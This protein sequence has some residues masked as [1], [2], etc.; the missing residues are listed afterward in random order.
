MSEEKY[1]L[2][3]IV[4]SL[5]TPFDEKGRVDFAS[6]ERLVETHL[7]EGAVG[8]LTTA[9]AAE[10]HELT[11][12]E[13]VEIVRLVKAVAGGRAEV[14]AG[15]TARKL[16][17]SLKLSEI[18]TRAGCE[19]VLIE[20]PATHKGDHG[21]TAEFVESFASVGMPMLMLQDLD[22]NGKGLAVDL[23]SDMFQRIEPFKCLKVEVT[24]C[25]PKYTTVIEATGGRLHVSGG[26]ASL[27]MIEALDRGVD[28]FLP[29]AMTK[30]FVAVM[31]Q[32]GAG[33]RETAK[34]VFHVMLPILAFT[35]Q[36][37]DVSIHFH[38]RLYHSRGVFTT[39]TVRIR[40]HGFDAHHQ[41]HA[42]ELIRYLD[43]VEDSS[44]I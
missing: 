31:D 43:R 8:F 35:R 25:G 7:R 27:Q 6:L 13:R 17:E 23:I 34:D 10:V 33:N 29:T 4:V 1:Q 28:A 19:G 32:Y 21:A 9:Q 20:V 39:P 26:W 37:L 12:D 18:A 42:E 3:G 40:S 24:P 38:K 44:E 14:I 2:D 22:W 5:N 16:G 36:H 41:R 11:F 15:A 30:L